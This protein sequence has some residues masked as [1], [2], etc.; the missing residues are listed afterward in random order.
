VREPELQEQIEAARTHEALF[1]PA[2][3]GPWAPLVADAARISPGDR[4]QDVREMVRVLGNRETL[5]D[6]FV[7]GGLI[8]A[9]IDSLVGTGEFPSV[10]A[11]V[12]ADLRGWLPVM[13]VLL[14]EDRIEAI[15]EEAHRTLA[16][17]VTPEGRVVFPTGVRIVAG[18]TA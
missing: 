3:F 10:R 6:L 16:S 5:Y 12:E 13:G 11:M 15:L 17:W 7:E 18:S 8:G 4:V 9:R 1:V 14:P 2:L